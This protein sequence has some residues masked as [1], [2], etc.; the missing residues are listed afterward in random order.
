MGQIIVLI[1]G[2]LALIVGI[3]VLAL[4]S[5]EGFDAEK[6]KKISG[7]RNRTVAMLLGVI[8]IIIGGL[9]VLASVFVR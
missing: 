4:V 6:L 9:I 5:G 8:G 1:L 2:I 3:R 7:T